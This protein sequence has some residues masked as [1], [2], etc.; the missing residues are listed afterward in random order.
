MWQA[1]SSNHFTSVEYLRQSRSQSLDGDSPGSA[2]TSDDVPNPILLGES[3][4]ARKLRSQI[5]R[6]APYLRTALISGEAGSG[7]QLVGRAV[8]ALSPGVHGPFIVA[9]AVALAE[10]VAD[11]EAAGG[12]SGTSAASVLESADGGTLYLKGVGELSFGLQAALF[13]FLRVCEERRPNPA[14]TMRPSLDQPYRRRNGAK[15]MSMRI[16]AASDRDLRLLSSV[17]QFR[18]DLYARLAAVEIFVPPLRQRVEDIPMLAQWLL[19]RLADG[20]GIGQKQFAKETLGQLQKGM[21]AGNLGELERVVALAAAL[22]EGTAIEP[23]HLLALVEP[24]LANQV[25]APTIKIERLNDV[26][27]RH[28]LEVLTRCGGNKLRAADLLGISR[29]T[30]YRMLEARAGSE[31]AGNG[32]GASRVR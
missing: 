19:C 16:L 24:A 6:I 27:Q 17:G 15:F 4:A 1:M 26:V 12:T 8:H 2:S 20:T 11:G 13:R 7:K 29:S 22:A 30:L 3:V 28:V 31:Q 25:T 14:K 32:D 21:W 9:T 23:R 18:Q 10:S 5:Q